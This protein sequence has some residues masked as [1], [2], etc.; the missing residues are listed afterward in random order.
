MRLAAAGK[1]IPAE[2]VRQIARG[3]HLAAQNDEREPGALRL[4]PGT[5]DL[6]PAD[7]AEIDAAFG[8]G[9]NVDAMRRAG[10][11]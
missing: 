6:T 7:L 11:L 2:P 1:R 8:I 4:V 9:Q 5:G 3:N 10:W